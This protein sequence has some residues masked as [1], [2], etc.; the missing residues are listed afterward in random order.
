MPKRRLVVSATTASVVGLIISLAGLAMLLI[1]R[2]NSVSNKFIILLFIFESLIWLNSDRRITPNI[3]FTIGW[4]LPAII[5]FIPLRN[6][7]YSE[8]PLQYEAMFGILLVSAMFYVVSIIMLILMRPIDFYNRTLLFK[9]SQCPLS[10]IVGLFILSN[11][12][13]GIAALS[14]RFSFPLFQVNITRTAFEYFRIQGSGSLFSMGLIASLLLLLRAIKN[15][16]ESILKRVRGLKLFAYVLFSLYVVELI[17]VG[18]RMGIILLIISSVAA[19]GR[20]YGVRKRTIAY[21][22]IVVA[23]VVVGNGFLRGRF[24][25]SQYWEGKSF[26]GI[27]STAA[28]SVIQPVLY[29]RGAFQSLGELINDSGIYGH[30]TLY[31]FSNSDGAYLKNADDLFSK[32]AI[33]AQM[34]TAFGAPAFD[35]GICGIVLWSIV[36]FTPLWFLYFRSASACMSAFCAI[37][38]AS[39]A[40]LWTGNFL[41]NPTLYYSLFVLIAINLVVSPISARS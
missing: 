8:R 7:I 25:F 36:I 4:Y 34:T 3:L 11:I 17:L 12:G 21:V 41:S 24:G 37:Y 2:S 38:A 5:S 23:T 18:K 16:R 27:Q 1:L 19:F 6:L 30:G 22:I 14:V 26:N 13:F 10:I 20:I 40:L 33:K 28:F 31:T 29:T 39:C 35:F 15:G 9:K 32:M